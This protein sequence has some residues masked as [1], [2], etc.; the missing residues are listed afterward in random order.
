MEKTDESTLKQFLE[1]GQAAQ[2]AVD[3]LTHK[4]TITMTILGPDAGAIA[5]GVLKALQNAATGIMQRHKNTAV[6][7]KLSDST[8][9]LH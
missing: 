4:R 3:R 9:P 5:G 7:V 1:K 8:G 6:D 2:K